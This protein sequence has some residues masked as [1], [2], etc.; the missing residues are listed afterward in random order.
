[1]ID[2]CAVVAHCTFTINQC[3]ATVSGTA[4]SCWFLTPN[5]NLPAL[6]EDLHLL[7]FTEYLVH[8][9]LESDRHSGGPRLSLGLF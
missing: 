6:L 9:C 4:F 8:T 5:K 1:M 7:V 2:V 3:F